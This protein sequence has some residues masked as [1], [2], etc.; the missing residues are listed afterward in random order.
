MKKALEEC[1]VWYKDTCLQNQAIYIIKNV[2]TSYYKIGISKNIHRRLR[3]LE[4]QSGCKLQLTDWY[5]LDTNNPL[6][7][8]DIEQKLH[9]KYKKFNVIGEWFNLENNIDDLLNDFI[10]LCDNY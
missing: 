9:S 3:Q 4:L 1:W 2:N 6:K 5:L 8:K 7:A 10:T